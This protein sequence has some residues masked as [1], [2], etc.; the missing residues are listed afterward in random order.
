MTQRSKQLNNL[1][2]ASLKANIQHYQKLQQ[3][4]QKLADE[5]QWNERKFQ[6]LLK[7]KDNGSIK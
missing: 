3:Q 4:Y 5:A 6:E 7:E 2:L 1:S